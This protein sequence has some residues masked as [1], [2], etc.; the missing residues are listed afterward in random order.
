MTVETLDLQ[1]VA[2]DYAGRGWHIIP[3]RQGDKRPAFPNH[4]ATR[5]TGRDPRCRAAGRHVGWEERATTDPDRI[6]RAWSATPYNIGV[7]TGPSGL[8][9]IDLDTSKPGQ[10]TAPWAAEGIHDGEDILAALC[11]QA[12]QEWPGGTYTVTTGRGGTHLYYQHPTIGPH[13]RNTQGGTTGS[14]GWLIDTRAHGGYVV[15]AGSTVSGNPY[16]VAW[17]VDPAPLPAWLADRLTPKPL[18]PQQPV[19]VELGT[20]RHAAYVRAAIAR[21]IEQVTT[22]PEGTRNRALYLSAL[23]LG[24]LVAGGALS[25]Q[26]VTGVLTRAAVDSGLWQREAR[27]TIASGL[28]AGVARPRSVA[29]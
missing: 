8:V 14:L 25:E 29:A 13:L 19:T 16:T 18:P 5:C 27:R 6:R 15:A 3:L 1:R 26:D 24:Q 4:D 21:Q 28:R 23:A 12:G 2:L 11:E 10:D 7:A 9:V 17:P 20:G 22:A